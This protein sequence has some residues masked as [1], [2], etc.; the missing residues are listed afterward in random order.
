M[1]ASF[2]VF[3]NVSVFHLALT[4]LNLVSYALNCLHIDVPDPFFFFFWKI[5]ASSKQVAH[6]WHV[7]VPPP[8]SNVQ[9]LSCG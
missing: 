7:S 5:A 3:F 1:L 4:I 6:V 8:I 9:S 2:R